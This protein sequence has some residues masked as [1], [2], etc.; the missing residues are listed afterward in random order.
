[1]S[2]KTKY[3]R[4]IFFKNWGTEDYPEKIHNSSQLD[5]FLKKL[6]FVHYMYD[7]L[8]RVMIYLLIMKNCFKKFD[9]YQRSE[10]SLYFANI[11]ELSM[12]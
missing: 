9:I 1:M 5:N 7:N 12:N 3:F 4:V 2:K 6:Q 8:I 11:H 10:S